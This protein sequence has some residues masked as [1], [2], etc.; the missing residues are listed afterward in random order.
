MGTVNIGGRELRVLDKED[1]GSFNVDLELARVGEEMA[2][3]QSNVERFKKLAEHVFCYVRHNDGA[4]LDWL[5]GVLPANIGP[6]M[7][8]CAKA[9]GREVVSREP[10]T[11]EAK[12]PETRV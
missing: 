4:T 10:G 5:I 9:A 8:A 7:R 11:G 2:S 1:S 3:A 6:V 12:A